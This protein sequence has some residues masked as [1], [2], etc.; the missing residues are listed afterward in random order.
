M[1]TINIFKIVAVIFFVGVF[2]AC[3]QDDDYSVPSDLGVTENLKLQELLGDSE[4]TELTI[5]EV[6]NQFSTGGAN[7]ILS[8][9]YVKG[10]VVSSDESGNFY[11]EF[12]IQ[13]HPTNPT[14]GIKVVLN[15]SDTFT[16]YN[17]GREVYINL[18]GLYVGETNSFDGVIALGGNE[19]GSELG[20][21]SVNQIINQVFRSKN[22][23][24]I[25]PLPVNVALVNNAHI[26]MFVRLDNMEFASSLAGQSYVNSNDDFDSSRIMQACE[27]IGYKN[28]ILETSTFADFKNLILPTGNGAISGIVTN[29]YDGDNMVIALNSPN[30]VDFNSER[31]TPLDTSLFTTVFEEDFES[32]NDNSNLDIPNWTNFA[33]EGGEL[34]TEQVS[35]GLKFS[36]FKCSGTSDI[37]NIGW[38]V[39]PGINMDVQTSEFL[40]F[41]TAKQSITSN[42]NSIEVFVST[43]Y[44]GS[45]VLAATWDPISANLVTMSDSSNVFVNSGF[46]DISMYT[47]TLYVAFKVIGSGTDPLLDGTYRVDNVR[48]LGM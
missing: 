9:V 48:V 31:C 27:G 40:D 34:W 6:K 5:S 16:K 17:F 7:Q 8:K 24:A 43:D 20:Q 10:Y 41:K 15:M 3:V 37:T 1:E 2:T 42:F 18:E 26:G 33:E 19:D 47:G 14:A 38:L 45:D 29:D 44:D 11:K 22:T 21:I 25:S 23:L 35:S 28:F 4:F 39:S 32:A 46:I 12:Y 36:E 30:D 13:D